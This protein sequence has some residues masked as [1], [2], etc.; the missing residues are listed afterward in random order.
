MDYLYEHPL[1]LHVDQANIQNTGK[2]CTMWL[3]HSAAV[4]SGK[5]VLQVDSPNRG[6]GISRNIERERYLLALYS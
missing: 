6:H 2:P 1:R 5:R 4:I 3:V